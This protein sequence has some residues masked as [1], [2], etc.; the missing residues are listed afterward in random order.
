M[1]LIVDKKFINLISGSLRN[2]KWQRNSL[3]NCSCPICGDSKKDKRKARGYFYEKHS[4]YFYKC[5]NCGHWSNLYKFLNAVN[6]ELAKEYSLES[7]RN[8]KIEPMLGEKKEAVFISKIKKPRDKYNVLKN[9][10]RLKDLDKDHMA[11]KFA[12]IR[13]IPKQHWN[14]LYFTDDFGSLMKNMDPEA[15]AV[16]AEPRLVIPFFNSHGDVVAVQGRSITLKDESNAR[17]TI[18]YLTVKSDKSI[19]RLWYG[20]WRCNPKKRVYAV[21]G[22][23]D[24]LFLKNA[25]A[26]VGAGSIGQTPARLQNSEMVYVLDNEPRNKQI[27]RY[28]ENLIEMG[29]KVCIWPSSVMDKDINDMAYKISTRDIQKLIDDNTYSGL[30]ARVK[31]MEWKK[32]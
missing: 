12:D 14:I 5:H 9:L 23:I 26:M 13:I 21:E 10:P 27:A 32:I 2:F 7:I 29:K 25:V 22:P 17:K 20:L 1:S 4:R 16:G 28:N 31:F 11:V 19:D 30:E 8:S 24:S 18:K 3:A 6:P 15:P